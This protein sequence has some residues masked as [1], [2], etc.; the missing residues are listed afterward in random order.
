M[1]RIRTTKTGSGKLSVQVCL[2]KTKKVV[3]IKHIGTAS[4]EAELLELKKLA[5]N[6]IA[7]QDN[8]PLL[9]P[10]FLTE[11]ESNGDFL[12]NTGNLKFIKTTHLFSY[13]FLCI[14]YKEN[15][16][17]KL[18][19]SILKDLV[20]ARILEPSSKLQ[21]IKFLRKNFGIYYPKN[22]IY[23][24]LLKISELK[25]MAEDIAYSYATRKYPKT[26]SL[27]FYDVTTL[28]FET[29]KADDLRKNGF[30]KDNKSNQPQILIGLLVNRDGY[31][32][33]FDIFQG[34]TFE[35]N[36]LIPS[37]L[38][39]KKKRAIRNLTV[40]ADAG[41]ISFKN[42]SE[43]TKLG[44]NYIV[45]AR[46]SN[47]K[48]NLLQKISA[49]LGSTEGVYTKSETD[50]GI[51][52]CNY[53]IKR[54][55]KNRS[56]RK[57]QIQKANSQIQNPSSI[58]KRSRFLTQENKLNFKLNLDL[59]KKDEQIEG[60]KGYYTN[61]S[62]VNPNLIVSRYKDLWRVEKSFRIA[63]SDLE[64]RPIYHFKETS[65]KAH[66]LIV[67]I[68]L[69]T[70]KSIELK[71][72]QSIKKIK[73]IIWDIEDITFKDKLTNKQVTKRMEVENPQIK[74]LYP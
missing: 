51:L 49:E 30:S 56:D 53:S 8:F 47:L 55:N 67:F 28:Y 58:T 57:K 41:M 71:V 5:V 31:P 17:E 1:L 59:I 20:I 7:T 43:L 24:Y 9:S 50:K 62:Q 21:T 12:V 3:V 13:E 32:I 2:S 72:N 14:W 33:S 39:L 40:V 35:G 65:I 73:E 42:I 38:N 36:T 15:G 74:T 48:E 25:E 64:A 37:I 45:G 10:S 54:A 61:L 52:I 34:N 44:L 22:K 11:T 69:A 66:I 68:S 6:Y 18:G 60:I 23:D 63:K 19:S 4:N 46:I 27:I 70:T 26:F 16:F 29:N